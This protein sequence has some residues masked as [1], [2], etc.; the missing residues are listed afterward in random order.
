[1]P[2]ANRWVKVTILSMFL[3]YHS[4]PAEVIIKD[5]RH[6]KTNLEVC[7]SIVVGT[8]HEKQISCNQNCK[9][10][11]KLVSTIKKV[12]LVKQCDIV[13]NV[14]ELVLGTW[15]MLLLSG[16]L[17]QVDL[18]SGKREICFGACGIM[19]VF[20][21]PVVIITADIIL[22]LVVVFSLKGSAKFAG[23]VVDA[24]C[25][26][27]GEGHDKLVYIKDSLQGAWANGFLAAQVITGLIG[28]SLRC[29]EWFLAC[30]Q[31]EEEEEEEKKKEK[32]NIKKGETRI[33]FWVVLSM[34]I[35][36]LVFDVGDYVSNVEVLNT[37][38]NL[39]QE[40][41][42][43]TG[44]FPDNSSSYVFSDAGLPKNEGLENSAILAIVVAV[45]LVASL[46][47]SILLYCGHGR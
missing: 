7:K 11:K 3:W 18:P 39:I 23:E 35:S 5:T 24:K 40:K 43:T 10:W 17:K 30:W 29:R 42:S 15:A 27:I 44:E 21:T 47:L 32:S 13:C 25:F 36:S 46:V 37:F 12:V 31:F 16:Q 9:D 26:T 34:S 45:F 20:V 6:E 1:M 8:A 4:F 41:I 33:L 38:I 14:V 22:P 28:G 2:G 19:S